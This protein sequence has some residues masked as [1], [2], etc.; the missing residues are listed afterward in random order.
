LRAFKG[1]LVVANVLLGMKVFYW[2]KKKKLARFQKVFSF[3]A[4]IFEIN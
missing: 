2:K 3:F 1:L 4:A